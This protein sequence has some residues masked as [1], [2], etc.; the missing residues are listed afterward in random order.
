MQAQHDERGRGERKWRR[1]QREESKE[2]QQER[3]GRRAPW[4]RGYVARHSAVPV[5]VVSESESSQA[6]H[7]SSDAGE[8]G[9]LVAAT[10]T[11]RKMAH[12]E[13]GAPCDQGARGVRPLSG[14][15]IENYW[16]ETDAIMNGSVVRLVLRQVMSCRSSQG[17]GGFLD[18]DRHKR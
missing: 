10:R 6:C 4:P 17:L 14:V 2:A 1:G 7:Q 11:R 8:G 15:A 12:A 9:S 5:A 3:R 16:G 18:A 13:S